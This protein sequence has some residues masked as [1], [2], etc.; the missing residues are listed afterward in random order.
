[1][2]GMVEQALDN[3]E[4]L[5]RDIVALN[6]GTALFAAGRVATIAEGVALARETLA[7]GAARGKLEQFVATTRRL[8][9]KG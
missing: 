8:A 9:G 2:L 4:G 7:S 3:V 1:M 6:S 5:P